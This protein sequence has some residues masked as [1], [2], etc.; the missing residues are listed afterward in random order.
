MDGCFWYMDLKWLKL[1][2]YAKRSLSALLQKSSFAV[3]SQRQ[4]LHVAQLFSNLKSNYLSELFHISHI[5]TKGRQLPSNQLPVQCKTRQAVQCA[6]SLQSPRRPRS[7]VNR[8]RSG[9][10]IVNFELTSHFILVFLLLTLNRL[11][12][13]NWKV[14]WFSLV[15][16]CYRDDCN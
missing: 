5:L 2:K 16:M 4:R 15:I 9:V 12:L 13:N 3:V 14:Q 7:N 8:C 1:W 10:F 6:W 11:M